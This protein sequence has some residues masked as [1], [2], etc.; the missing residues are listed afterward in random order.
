MKQNY[1]LIEI[2][3]QLLLKREQQL[4]FYQPR[5]MFVSRPKRGNSPVELDS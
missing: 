5:R 4:S 2:I 1:Q 3:F